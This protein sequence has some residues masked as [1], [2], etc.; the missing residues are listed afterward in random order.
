[1]HLLG[2]KTRLK[3]NLVMDLIC[4]ICNLSIRA[5][6]IQQSRMRTLTRKQQMQTLFYKVGKESAIGGKLAEGLR[7]PFLR[8]E[9]EGTPLR[10]FFRKTK[11]KLPVC[12]GEE[13]TYLLLRFSLFIRH[14]A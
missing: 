9:V 4:F 3:T 1:M 14:L 8:T 11:Q 12:F 6:S 5:A 10:Y 13:G 2:Q 7:L